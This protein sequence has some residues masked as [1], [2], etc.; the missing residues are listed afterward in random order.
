MSSERTIEPR[1]RL[2]GACMIAAATGLWLAW[3]LM[4]DAATNDPARILVQIGAHRPRVW[5]SA[6]VQLAACAAFAPAVLQLAGRGGRATFAGGALLLIGAMGMA[7]DAVYHQAA[8][9]VAAPDLDP[10]AVVPVLARMQGEDIKSLIPLLLALFV[11]APLLAHGLAREGR[12]PR[13]VARLL[14][15]AFAFALLGALAAKFLAVPAR[16]VALG[17]LGMVCGGLAALGVAALRRGR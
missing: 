7:A 8:Y 10:A 5:L 13:W 11:G 2:A 15:L 1:D 9:Q 16:V 14:L 6:L 17:F 3:A 4:P 12:A